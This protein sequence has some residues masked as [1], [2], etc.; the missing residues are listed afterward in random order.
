ML[1]QMEAR[2]NEGVLSLEPEILSLQEH[3][4]NAVYSMV[5]RA[6]MGRRAHK[7]EAFGDVTLNPK[8]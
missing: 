5:I 7:Q 8:A 6:H 4:Q 2:P 1:S 3:P